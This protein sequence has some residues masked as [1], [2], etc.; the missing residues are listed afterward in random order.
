MQMFGPHPGKKRKEIVENMSRKAV[1]CIR[2]DV[3]SRLIGVL[4]P[5]GPKKSSKRIFKETFLLN[6]MHYGAVRSTTL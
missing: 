5:E 2:I 6:K 4:Y 1:S 3:V